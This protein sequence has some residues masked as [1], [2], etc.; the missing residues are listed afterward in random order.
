MLSILLAIHFQQ[1]AW[2][3]G[4]GDTTK[5]GKQ[6]LPPNRERERKRKIKRNVEFNIRK[7]NGLRIK[8]K[9][10]NKVIVFFVNLQTHLATEKKKLKI[11]IIKKNSFVFV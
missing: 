3:I 5:K 6:V 8:R 2:R 9:K 7:K 10:K 1:T 11:I 4:G